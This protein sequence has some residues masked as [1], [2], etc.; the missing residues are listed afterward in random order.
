MKTV[1]LRRSAGRASA[2]GNSPAVAQELSSS[3]YQLTDA[4]AVRDVTLGN[5]AHGHPDDTQ[6][7]T[8]IDD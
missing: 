6:H 7:W 5:W 4:G 8:P 2:E 3:L 1:P